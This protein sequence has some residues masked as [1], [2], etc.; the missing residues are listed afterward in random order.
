MNS[1]GNRRVG[2]PTILELE[3]R[4]RDTPGVACIV[5]SDRNVRKKVHGI[6][7]EQRQQYYQLFGSDART[8]SQHHAETDQQ[9]Q[10]W[11]PKGKRGR[12]SPSGSP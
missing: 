10:A 7:S 12:R 9:N 1:S 4:R 8:D 2:R 3:N 11:S 6:T 5:S